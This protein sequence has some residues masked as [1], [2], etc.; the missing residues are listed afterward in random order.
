[1]FSSSCQQ[2]LQFLQR[3]A[4]A[5]SAAQ[6]ACTTYSNQ[7]ANKLAEC[8]GRLK[9][10]KTTE[11]SRRALKECKK[12]QKKTKNTNPTKNTT[13]P[14]RPISYPDPVQP[15]DPPKPPKP[16]VDPTPPTDLPYCHMNTKLAYNW[17][18][19]DATCPPKMRED[20]FNQ[21]HCIDFPEN[22]AWYAR[23]QAMPPGPAK[24]AEFQKY[25]DS[26]TA[27]SKTVDTC[28]DKYKIPCKPVPGDWTGNDWVN[29]DKTGQVPLGK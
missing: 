21:F 9:E 14:S 17:P 3:K 8:R 22:K 20:W 4:M 10:C 29:Y 15:N 6:F 25:L 12:K 27:Y 18:D 13:H 16:P 19:T 11:K 28:A 7:L 1:M 5:D 2:K 26:T 24:D 23:I